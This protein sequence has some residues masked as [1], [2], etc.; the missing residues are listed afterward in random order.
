[1]GPLKDPSKLKELICSSID[2]MSNVEVK[3]FH[4]KIDTGETNPYEMNE[5]KIGTLAKSGKKRI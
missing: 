5:I 3:G 4:M 2:R 1:M